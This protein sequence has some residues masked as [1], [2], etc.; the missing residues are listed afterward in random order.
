MK[1]YNVKMIC[2]ELSRRFKLNFVSNRCMFSWNVIE[3]GIIVDDEIIVFS[4]KKLIDDTYCQMYASEN[5]S[6]EEII[7]LLSKKMSKLYPR[8]YKMYS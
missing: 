7:V 4:S 6:N 1:K 8:K 2:N 5:Y 3:G